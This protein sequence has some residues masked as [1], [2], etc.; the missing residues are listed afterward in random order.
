[1]ANA[2]RYVRLEEWDSATTEQRQ[3]WLDE[4]VLLDPQDVERMIARDRKQW[5]RKRKNAKV[6]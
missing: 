6:C 5:R 2:V 4:G 1:M 3:K